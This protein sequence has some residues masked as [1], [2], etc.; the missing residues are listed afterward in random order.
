MGT[1]HPRF[2]WKALRAP[3]AVSLRAGPAALLSASYSLR[4]KAEGEAELRHGSARNIPL[5]EAR[6]NHRDSAGVVW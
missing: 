2:R 1:E 6:E 3:Y 5:I 4:R